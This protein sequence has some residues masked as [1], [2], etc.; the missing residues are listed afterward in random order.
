MTDDDEALELG[1]NAAASAGTTLLVSPQDFVCKKP[2]AF[3]L[4]GEIPEFTI[5][6]ETYGTLNADKSNAVLICHALTGDHHVAGKHRPSDARAGWWDHFIGEGKAVDT[7]KYFV[8]CSNCLGGCSGSTGPTSVNPATGDPYGIDFPVLTMRDMVR[9]QKALVEHL[10]I[11]KLHAVIG[12]SM[13]GMQTLLWAIE[14]PD[15]V[16]NIVAMACAARQNEQA[17]AFNAVA[18]TAIVEDPNW[19]GG[20]YGELGGTGPRTGLA[21]ARMMAHITYLSDLS[22]TSK[23]HRNPRIDLPGGRTATADFLRKITF[24]I[25]SYLHH[26]GD[27]FLERFDANSYLYISQ[28]T[29]RF[30][31]SSD[32]SLD[33]ALAPVKA[34]VLVIGFSTDWLYPPWQNREI[35][36][37]LKRTGKDAR[38][39][40]IEAVNGHDSFLLDSQRLYALTADFLAETAPANGVPADAE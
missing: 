15:A 27:K 25:D 14:Y 37:A 20:Y 2:F 34:R 6:Y 4:G 26:Q 21:V 11:R 13:G 35:V 23:T 30:N 22:L 1:G 40:E 39:A 9:A 5:R 10:G 29:D 33:R 7:R 18:R 31:I 36:L 19:F 3:E 16:A 17:I 38:Y 12:G 24:P 8:I 32:H 28:A